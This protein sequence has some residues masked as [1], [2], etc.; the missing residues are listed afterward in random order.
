M[1][2]RRS[3][4]C[5]CVERWD[6]RSGRITLPVLEADLAEQ[7]FRGIESDTGTKPDGCPWRALRDP[8]VRQVLH[9][10]PAWK[11]GHDV[12]PAR[13]RNAVQAYHAALNAIEVA[14]MKRE[15]KRREAKKPGP[16]SSPS[17]RRRR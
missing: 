16:P 10:Y 14:D 9:V 6:A 15:R 2:L 7:A 12:N 5:D 11:T 3:Y 13:L 1:G 4:R 17:F 8:F